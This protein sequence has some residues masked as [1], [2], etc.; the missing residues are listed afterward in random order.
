MPQHLQTEQ[1]T[2]SFTE[3]L[4]DLYSITANE[5]GLDLHHIKINTEEAKK[6]YNDGFTPYVTF[7]ETYSTT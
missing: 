6:W 4:S 5:T 7:R 2:V 1:Q 3:W